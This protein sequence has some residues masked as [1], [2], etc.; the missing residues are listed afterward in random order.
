MQSLFNIIRIRHFLLNKLSTLAG[1]FW[2]FISAEVVKWKCE[3]HLS[4]FK[5]TK[6][7][8]WYTASLTSPLHSLCLFSQETLFCIEVYE[9]LWF[10]ALM[11]LHPRYPSPIFEPRFSWNTSPKSHLQCVLSKVFHKDHKGHKSHRFSVNY[12]FT[13]SDNDI[14]YKNLSYKLETGK[15]QLV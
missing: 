6:Q 12:C 9:Q 2:G 10:L 5:N 15:F 3:Q 13:Y 4:Y 7:C 14:F 1:T 11:F 8:P